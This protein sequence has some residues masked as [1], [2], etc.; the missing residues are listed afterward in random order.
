[1]LHSMTGYGRGEATSNGT[2]FTVELQSVN[3]K[4]SDIAITL[5]R[6]LHRLEGRV[7]DVLQSRITR[8]R[9]N[10]SILVQ[11]AT[12]SIQASGIDY[13]LAASFAAAMAE[14]KKRLNLDGELTLDT[15]L[16]A[17]GVLQASA[18]EL[19]P[20]EAWPTLLEA[21]QKAL[22][23]LLE[24]RRF[25]G[26]NL[27]QDLASR[28]AVLRSLLAQVRSRAPELLARHRSLLHERV[29]AAGLEIPIDDERIAREVVLYA[30][31]SDVSEEITRLES[32]FEQFEKLLTSD[33]PIG[34][35]LEFLTQEIA[36]EL[37]TLSTKSCDAPVSHW[38]VESKAELEKIREQIHNVE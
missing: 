20:E 19:D 9:L 33:Q 1:M 22:S 17:P 26:S 28:L 11:P 10:A 4:Q 31:R 36:R 35:T 3:R 21:L 25:E 13:A 24:M 2:R 30:D 32:H 15:V 16:R 29:R 7:R 23:G 6:S 18:Q 8:G 27:A 12:D 14:L 38:I 37:N 34:R 5:P